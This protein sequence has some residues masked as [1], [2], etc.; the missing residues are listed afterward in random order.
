MSTYKEIV[1]LTQSR[2][3]RQGVDMSVADIRKVLDAYHT[4]VLRRIMMG[5]IAYT[6][7]GAI[8]V[9]RRAAQKGRNP[10]TDATIAIPATNYPKIRFKESWKVA[11]N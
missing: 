2:L 11:I 3:L 6:D 4:V 5:D 9:R 1:V 10:R 8:F 7:M